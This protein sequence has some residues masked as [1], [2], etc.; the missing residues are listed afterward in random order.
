IQTAK[1]FHTGVIEHILISGGNGKIDVASF[2][3]AAFV[4]RELVAIGV[5]DS[6]I[7]MEDRS[8]NTRDNAH[9]A[10]LILDSL[11]LSP[12]YLLISSAMHLPRAELLFEKSGV[13]V[14]PFPAHYTA[15]R[16][17]VTFADFVPRVPTLIAWQ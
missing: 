15:G 16:S 5:P 10:R 13:A 1:M 8:N 2:R 6:V 12:P 3:E 17:G 4:K 14:D 11:Q 9:F 7:Y